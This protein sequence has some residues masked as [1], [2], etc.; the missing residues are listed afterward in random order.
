[1]DITEQ[2]ALI[3]D[4]EQLESV[5]DFLD[6]FAIEYSRQV[7]Q[8]KHIPLLRL[9]RQLLTAKKAT[10]SYDDY[11]DALSTAYGQIARGRLPTV[12]QS[13]CATCQSDCDK[14]E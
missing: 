13:A 7:V 5:E 4:L 9:C 10:D 12:N 14:T 11:R 3:E 1:M 6:Y 2:R 8:S